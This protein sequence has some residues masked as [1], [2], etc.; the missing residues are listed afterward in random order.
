MFETFEPAEKKLE[1]RLA[2]SSPSFRALGSSFWA[3]VVGRARAEIV[4]RRDT[5]HASAFLLSESSLFVFDRRLVMITCGRSMLVAAALHLV[6]ALGPAAFD[7]LNFQRR[8]ERSPERQRSSFEAD[9]EALRAVLPGGVSTF[10]APDSPWLQSFSFRRSGA[11]PALHTKLELYMH[12]VL[13]PDT[14]IS[15]LVTG[16]T[17]DEHRF[18]PEGYSMNAVAGDAHRSLHL[19]TTQEGTYVG[20]DAS[21][22]DPLVLEALADRALSAFRPRR[23]E[24]V[25]ARPEQGPSVV[26]RAVEP[27]VS[28]L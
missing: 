20:L 16:F 24:I 26:E 9:A 3:E 22:L 18:E 19:S 5:E 21:G 15:P 23:W 2:A 1:L 8:R 17:L 10:G 13:A 6:D 27:R 28:Y 7:A 11:E 25:L 4:A 14:D 12:E